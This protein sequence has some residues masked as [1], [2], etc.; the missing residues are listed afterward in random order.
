MATKSV[1]IPLSGAYNTRVNA[2][3]S[4]DTSSGVIGVGVIGVMIIGKSQT[5]TS[6]DQRF[7]NCFPEKISDPLNGSVKYYTIKR[8]GV[9][10]NSTPQAGSIGTAILVWSGQGTGQKVIS[11]FGGTNSTIY[12]A[13]VSIGTIT[14]MAT[15]I[16]ETLV[17]TTATLVVPSTD[18]TAWYYDTGVGTMTKITDGD[19]PGNAGYTLAGTFAHMDGFACIMTT[20]GKVWTSDLNSVTAWT[21]SSFGSANS[22]PDT[23]VG[24][25]RYKTYIMAFGTQSIQFFHNAGL[26]PF[27]LS[28]VPSMTVKLGAVSA[29]AITSISD[30]VFWCGSTPQGGIGVYQYS[31]GIS[32]VSPSEINAILLLAG[33][34]NISL[35]AIRFYGKSF[36]VV[37]ASANTFVYCVEEKTWHQW[38]SSVNWWYRFASVSSG[39]NMLNYAISNTVTGGKV[40]LMDNANLQF[41]DD[42]VAYSAVIQTALI[43]FG[44]M[45]RKFYPS[46]ELVCDK[47]ST[48]SDISLSWTDDDYQ[49]TTTWGT[50]DTS[51]ARTMADRCGS[52]RRRGWIWTHSANTPM[53][54][55][56]M[57]IEVEMGNN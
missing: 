39:T 54:I 33:A 16:T 40:Y 52:S 19:F 35:S 18:N 56:A 23:G 34:A 47:Q 53:R 7:L 15:D 31:D 21:A 36:V 57:E 20:D 45:K 32:I 26:T 28:N 10:V 12:D 44:T 3:N 24:L 17:S 49:T 1:R 43:D 48:T 30:V 27:P 41:T 22:Y 50:V 9:T 55:E 8:P 37:T 6:K 14:G 51:A 42:T 29:K 11:A 5:A 13:A 4:L 38:V 46:V 25:I 2:V